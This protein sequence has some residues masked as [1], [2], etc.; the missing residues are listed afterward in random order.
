MKNFKKMKKI[1]FLI[2]LITFIQCNKFKFSN[3]VC[4]PKAGKKIQC[5]GKHSYNCGD[6][7]CIT[8]QYHCHM[9]SIFS[10]SKGKHQEKYQSFMKRI[11]ECPEPPKYKWRPTDVC[12]K[13]KIC[14]KSNT[15]SISVL[16]FGKFRP[17]LCECSGKYS[18][19][20]KGNYC[21]L[22]KLG[23]DGLKKNVTEIKE[24]IN[25]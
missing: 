14:F 20:C 6:F 4:F 12:L 3:D 8:N 13:T 7:V 18:Y 16:T 1:I 23:C 21:G 25:Q 17:T 5:F 10:Y 2:F 15:I 24:C 22:N 19:K 9:L 11:K